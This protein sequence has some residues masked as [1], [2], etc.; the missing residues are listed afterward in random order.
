MIDQGFKEQN[1]A[2]KEYKVRVNKYSAPQFSDVNLHTW[3]PKGLMQ[4]WYNYESHKERSEAF[5]M[6]GPFYELSADGRSFYLQQNIFDNHRMFQLTKIYLPP[7]VQ[8]SLGATYNDTE[9]GMLG[10]AAGYKRPNIVQKKKTDGEI[11]ACEGVDYKGLKNKTISP[12]GLLMRQVKELFITI[13]A[14]RMGY[15]E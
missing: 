4:G 9:T 2:F 7:N 14:R 5:W 8:D 11:R 13:R 1:I 15:F 3:E 10:F 12:G 6:G